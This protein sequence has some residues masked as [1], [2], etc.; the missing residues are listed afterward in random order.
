MKTDNKSKPSAV[1]IDFGGTSVKIGSLSELL[2]DRNSKPKTLKT[3][4]FNTVDSLVSAMVKVVKESM[5]DA[6]AFWVFFARLQGPHL[7]HVRRS[8]D[9]SH[10]EHAVGAI[11][12]SEESGQNG[13]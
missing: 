9:Q 13:P 10:S 6:E 5:D 11:T 8:A 2:S 7:E 3:A 1:G 12:E 4:D